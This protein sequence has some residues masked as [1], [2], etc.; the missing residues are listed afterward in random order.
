MNM[1]MHVASASPKAL[2][3]T[4]LSALRQGSV[5]V[6]VEQ[7]DHHHFTF[8]DHGL[9]LEF[10]DKGRLTEFFTKTREL[11][12]D[13]AVLVDFLLETDDY[14]IA[15]WTLRSTMVEPFFGGLTRKVPIT[16]PG[17]S[18]VRTYGDKIIHWSDYYDGLMARRTALAAFF[19]AW[20]E[21]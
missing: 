5:G 20:V 2:L 15:E 10:G 19:T 6:A 11:Y 18:I 13:S 17:V 8:V 1:E 12:P 9:G 3:Q 21:L 16:L 14:V 4:V 7:F